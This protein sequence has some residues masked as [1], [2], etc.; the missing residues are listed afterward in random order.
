MDD[1]FFF[2]NFNQWMKTYL[3]I[4]FNK[5]YQMESNDKRTVNCNGVWISHCHCELL[6]WADSYWDFF[7]STEWLPFNDTHRH[8]T[9]ILNHMQTN[10][11]EP[12]P[13]NL[14]LWLEHTHKKENITTLY[15][16]YY[17]AL[18]SIHHTPQAF[19]SSN[20]EHGCI[21]WICVS[22]TNWKS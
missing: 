16:V 15:C 13:H 12:K 18:H 19:W 4:H 5:H 1:I 11:W 6:F 2:I 8:C 20:N 17:R 21:S 9:K 14:Y 3:S 7:P 22:D 10:K